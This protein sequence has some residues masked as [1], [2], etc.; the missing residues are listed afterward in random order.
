M[1]IS[2]YGCFSDLKLLDYLGIFFH[3]E[4]HPVCPI[5]RVE[6]ESGPYKG[7]PSYD[8]QIPPYL[9]DPDQFSL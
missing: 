3:L 1:T 8:A 9:H 5:M 4:I 7:T 2:N 6:E